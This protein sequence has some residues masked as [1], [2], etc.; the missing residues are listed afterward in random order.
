MT[1]SSY[2]AIKTKMH[3]VNL[4]LLLLLPWVIVI[5]LCVGRYDV[6]ISQAFRLLIS[7]FADIEPT[8]TWQMETAVLNIRLPRVL[9][10]CLVGSALG[11]AGTAFQSV[12]QNPMAAPDILG[13]SSAAA[14][15]AALSILMGLRSAGITIVAFL[16]SIISIFFVYIIGR[17]APGKKIVNLILG[18]MVISSFFSAATSYI[19]LVAD[20][21]NQLPSIVYWMMGSLS[22]RKMDDVVFALVPMLIAAV[23]LFLVRW[24][25]NVLTLSDEEAEAIGV[26][27]NKFRLLVIVCATLLTASAVSVSGLIG[28]VGLIVPHLC[29]KLVGN[30]NRVLVPCSMLLGAIFLLVVDDFSRNLLTTEIPIG[31]LT[32]LMGAPFFIYLITRKK[33]WS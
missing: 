4:V 7:T 5:S 21:I 20:P 15:G 28:W 24:K 14:F 3:M 30:D 1:N 33:G 18:G 8:W 9:L 10:A 17:K 23:P 19:K 13:A 22:G 26:N 11:L 29:R 31:I 2:K 12:F 6:P 27:V 16:F 25:I 32:A